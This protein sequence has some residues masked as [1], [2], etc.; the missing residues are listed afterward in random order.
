MAATFELEIRIN[1]SQ[2]PNVYSVGLQYTRAD[3][4]AV[5]SSVDGTAS[6]DFEEL[7]VNELDLEEYG[8]ILYKNLFADKRLQN[9]FESA[10]KISG[11]MEA[12]LRIRLFIAP[13]ADELHHLR[14]E[15]LS[16]SDDDPLLTNENILFSRY[17]SSED[18][19]PIRL[20]SS[21]LLSALIVVANPS[22]IGTYNI[23]GQPLTAINANEEIARTKKALAGITATSLNDTSKAT[24]NNLIDGLRDGYDILYV[25]CHG[26]LIDGE[27]YLWLED[28]DGKVARTD[29]KEFILRVNELEKRPRLIVLASCESAGNDDR[30]NAYKYTLAGLGPGL[31]AKGIPAVLAMQGKITVA[32][33]EKFMPAFFKEFSKNGQLEKAVTIARNAVRDRLDRWMPVLFTRL[34]TGRLLWW[35]EPGFSESNDNTKWPALLR[36]IREDRCA[37]IL[38]S[39]LT[40]SLFG[41]RGEIARQWAQRY[42]FPLAHH[43][44][45]DFTQVAQFLSVNQTNR[46]P[47]KEFE[48][49]LKNELIRR[50]EDKI[51]FKNEIINRYGEKMWQ[52][53]GQLLSN[54]PLDMLIN[55]VWD[56]QKFSPQAE[57]YKILSRLPLSVYI[58]TNP[59]DVLSYSLQHVEKEPQID[60]FN[61]QSDRVSTARKND[62]DGREYDDK[63]FD[64]DDDDENFVRD[65]NKPLVYHL[66]GRLNEL[67]SLILTEDDFFEYLISFGQNRELLPLPVRTRFTNTSL[68]FLGF[69]LDEWNFRVLFRSIMRLA[70]DGRLEDYP[71]VAVQIDPTESHNE[72]IKKAR[73]YFQEYF[74]KDDISIFKGS[75]EDFTT[76]LRERWKEEY[77]EDLG[78]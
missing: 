61:W 23:D 60:F 13:D 74:K 78:R 1:S 10:Y 65:P 38:G 73:L 40:E 46:F 12:R 75:V 28:E 53:M 30:N 34:K 33:V 41:S 77:G 39:G 69:Q 9:F 42:K 4:N 17:V 59:D 32:T 49:Y 50:Y 58:N 44:S 47:R 27:P 14:W 52:R 64:D 29:G 76:Q 15:L 26:A 66:F 54:A 16:A 70:K 21:V 3:Y 25:V 48:I 35:Y 8:Q 63:D 22:N 20:N 62:E 5:S 45:D 7:R 11:A 56:N 55:L 51:N 68:L 37:P 71:H 19:R 72:D 67:N 31:A 24:L 18:F 6:F 36:S 57:P 43:L 2:Q